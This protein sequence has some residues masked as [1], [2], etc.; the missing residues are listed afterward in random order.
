MKNLTHGRFSISYKILLRLSLTLNSL[1][2]NKRKQTN[3]Q[4]NLKTEMILSHSQSRN[5]INLTHL[6]CFKL[7]YL[8]KLY[9]ITYQL[10][11][12]LC[13]PCSFYQ[14]FLQSRY[15]SS[16]HAEHQKNTFEC[17]TVFCCYLFNPFCSLRSSDFH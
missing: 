9:V 17:I 7:Q 4:N 10:F 12:H 1:E 11:S 2:L 8:P 16:F 6:I 13:D 14:L 3:K 15:P 5:L